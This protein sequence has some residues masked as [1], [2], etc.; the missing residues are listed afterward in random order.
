MPKTPISLIAAAALTLAG[1]FA[2]QMAQAQ[3]GVQDTTA[4]QVQNC[5]LLGPVTES[6]YSGFLFVASG[7]KKARI[8][9][10]QTLG[11]M[12]ATH[13]V[14]GAKTTGVTQSVTGVGY[15]CN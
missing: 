15:R 8:K 7:V 11:A 13:V 14:W 9:V 10:R 12:G 1:G 4:D 5:T 2:P 3:S 6:R